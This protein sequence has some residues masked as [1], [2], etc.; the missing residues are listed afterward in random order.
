MRKNAEKNADRPD[1]KL[2]MDI[3]LVHP[4]NVPSTQDYQFVSSKNTKALNEKGAGFIRS[5][6]EN[7][8]R[9]L[10]IPALLKDYVD[11]RDKK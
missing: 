8:D 1:A 2:F 11:T 9:H 3:A 6:R 10:Y 5:Y 4:K 7:N